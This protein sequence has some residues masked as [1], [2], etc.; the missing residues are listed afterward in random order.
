MPRS[1]CDFRV[2][3]FLG[4]L[5][6]AFA[7]APD[8]TQLI[9]LQAQDR[10][11]GSALDTTARIKRDEVGAINRTLELAAAQNENIS[12]QTAGIV[13]SYQSDGYIVVL[14]DS[15]L[16]LTIFAY[17][18]AYGLTGIRTFMIGLDGVLYQKDL[19]PQT[20]RKLLDIRAADG[21]WQKVE[22]PFREVAL[23]ANRL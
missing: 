12:R 17:P 10:P 6:W 9:A 3:I 8:N 4:A 16:E 5:V 11:S 20:V 22:R 2:P 15:G 23:K 14:R 21:S 13:R 7:S 1:R 18:A 19:G